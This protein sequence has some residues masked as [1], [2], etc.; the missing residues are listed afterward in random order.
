MPDSFGAAD[1]T[2]ADL[3]FTGELEDLFDYLDDAGLDDETYFLIVAIGG[4][5]DV[6]EAEMPDVR[7]ETVREWGRLSPRT[8]KRYQSS[9]TLRA[10]AKA[11]YPSLPPGE[12]V[13]EW[14]EHGGN[15]QPGR[16]MI[17]TAEHPGRRVGYSTE[18]FKDQKERILRRT[19]QPEGGPYAL[20]IRPSSRK[21]KRPYRSDPVKLARKRELYARKVRAKGKTYR[22]RS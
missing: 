9:K 14:Y 19:S 2:A 12:A 6:G 1:V 18:K 13:R 7:T 20:Y 11:A 10:L 4:G 21:R 22:P 5:G 8:A 16:G 3:R 17:G 15:L